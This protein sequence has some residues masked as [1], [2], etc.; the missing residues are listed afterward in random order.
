MV[1]CLERVK[2]AV[3]LPLGVVVD[4]EQD[5]TANLGQCFVV[6]FNGLTLVEWQEGRLAYVTSSSAIAEGPHNM[7]CQ[8][9][10]CQLPRN[11]AET[12]CT[13]SREQIKV[14]KSEG[15]GGPMCNKHVHSTVTRSS[16]P[17]SYMC[18][19]QTDEVRVVDNTCVPTTCCGKVF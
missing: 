5:H 10:S 3:L 7:S 6:P 15:W 12:T 19:K 13:T 14:M 17:L 11:N 16:L 18:H 9:K 8:L 1:V 4:K 2:A